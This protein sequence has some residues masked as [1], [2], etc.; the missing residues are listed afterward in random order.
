MNS[1][2]NYIGKGKQVKEMEIVKVSI[3]LE[4]LEAIAYEMNGVKYVSFEVAK[5]KEAD[6]YGHTH[7]CYTQVLTETKEKKAKKK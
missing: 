1:V 3:K 7:T 2:K 6:Q 4:Q 5:L